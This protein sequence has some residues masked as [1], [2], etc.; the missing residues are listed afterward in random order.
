MLLFF[1]HL[2]NDIPQL[3]SLFFGLT[4]FLL[5]N[6]RSF[7]LLAILG[8]LQDLFVSRGLFLETDFFLLHNL[9]S[10]DL[11]SDDAKINLFLFLDKVSRIHEER[12][13]QGFFS[14]DPFQGVQAEQSLDQVQRR[15]TLHM[16][17]EKG[18]VVSECLQV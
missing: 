11:I 2:H 9:S 6:L 10:I 7:F 8:F 17:E 15:L 12:M 14:S 3:Q 5:L 13:F 16:L 18:H 4:W 1:I